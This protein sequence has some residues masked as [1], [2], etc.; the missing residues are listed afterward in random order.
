MTSVAIFGSVRGIRPAV[1]RMADDLSELGHEVRVIDLLGGKT[2]DSLEAALANRDA[3]G[4]PE[5]VRR[6]QAAADELPPQT[7][8]LGF[9]MGGSIA[10]HLAATRSG[11]RGAILIGAADDPTEDGGVWPTGVPVQVHY[12]TG[13]PWVEA[14]QLDALVASVHA[15]NAKIDVFEYAA[16]G[17]M[18]ADFGLPDYDPEAARLTFDRVVDF[19]SAV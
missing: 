5:L 3:I 11:A 4:V 16:G 8:Y 10:Q 1:L 18:F 19:L 15:A 13:D 2:F 17:H 7:V 14:T 6:A 12:A 9:S